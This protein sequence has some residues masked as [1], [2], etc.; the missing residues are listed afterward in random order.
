[1][2]RQK[3]LISLLLICTLLLFT[4]GCNRE[5]ADD[6]VTPKA[7][8]GKEETKDSKNTVT[9]LTVKSGDVSEKTITT[10]NEKLKER[11][12]S[13]QITVKTPEDE[14]HSSPSMYQSWLKKEQ[15][16]KEGDIIFTG[17][18]DDDIDQSYD[19]NVKRGMLDCMDDF[20]AGKAGKKLKKS[21]PDRIWKMVECKGKIYGF[22]MNYE[23]YQN[24]MIVDSNQVDISTLPK[25]I[26]GNT[27][28]SSLKKATQKGE[29]IKVAYGD[30]ILSSMGYII[31][32]VPFLWGVRSGDSYEITCILDEPD[33]Q[34]LLKQIV[35]LKSQYSMERYQSDYRQKSIYFTTWTAYSGYGN[36]V[37]LP[38]SE[39]TVERTTYSLG[40]NWFIPLRNEYWGVTSWS[41]K[42]TAAYDFLSLMCQ[43]K[44]LCDLLRKDGDKIIDEVPVNTWISSPV[45]AEPDNKNEVFW[46]EVEEAKEIPMG[47]AYPKFDDLVDIRSSFQ[48]IYDQYEG[49]WS[50]EYKDTSQTIKQIREKLEA[51]GMEAFLK[52]WNRKLKSK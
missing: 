11:G 10:F 52:K 44:E 32:D 30:A 22:P 38:G 2:I 25:K 45:G 12:K 3:S 18:G 16:K 50:G 39:Q 23:V 26:T 20:F 34:E 5:Q 7:T 1:M 46:K 31:T 17:Y 40:N 51:K 36:Q 4:S 15:E 9:I 37:V 48:D 24:L 21:Y 47:I 13:Y 6:L 19:Y 35:S 27:V 29:K 42:K 8:Q 28:F 41:K 14:F 33:C 43:D 49:L